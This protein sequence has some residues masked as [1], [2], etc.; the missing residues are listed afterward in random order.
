MEIQEQKD[1]HVIKFDDETV[2]QRVIAVAAAGYLCVDSNRVQ[3]AEDGMSVTVPFAD[4]VTVQSAMHF[5]GCAILPQSPS[6]Y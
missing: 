3:V 2:Q 1:R 6:S 4:G 5:L